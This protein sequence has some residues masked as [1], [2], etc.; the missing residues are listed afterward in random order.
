M[1]HYKYSEQQLRDA[2]QK[3]TSIRQTLIALGM[4]GKG[5]NYRVINK[6]IFKY[7]IDISHFT[8]KGW[9]KNKHFGPKRK[10]EEY[11]NNNQTTS[12]G[13]GNNSLSSSSGSVNVGLTTSNNVYNQN[14]IHED[15]E[16][17]GLIDISK[18]FEIIKTQEEE[19][20]FFVTLAASKILDYTTKNEYYLSLVFL[21]VCSPAN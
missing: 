20:I 7:N 8:G 12:G 11:L 4:A 16:E 21:N 14:I 17:E 3:S 10:I 5:G 15:N 19:F 2:I 1:P 6:A 9:S 13:T 18:I